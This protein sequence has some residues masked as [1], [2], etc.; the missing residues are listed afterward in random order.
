MRN[1]Q[2]NPWNYLTGQFNLVAGSSDCGD[3][4]GDRGKK[5]RHQRQPRICPIQLEALEQRQLLSTSVTQDLFAAT[6]GTVFNATNFP[7]WKTVNP[8]TTIPSIANDQLLVTV[9]VTNAFP[10]TSYLANGT[11]G[12]TS[13][14][15]QVTF[16]S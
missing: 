7:Q 11:A 14:V 9:S 2:S 5:R 8:T 4:K 3:S 16:S 10:K 1:L 6:S 15:Q 12:T 13:S